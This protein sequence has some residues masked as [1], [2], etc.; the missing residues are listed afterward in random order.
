[1]ASPIAGIRRQVV[2]DETLHNREANK[3]ISTIARMV[4]PGLVKR[5]LTKVFYEH[6]YLLY[7]LRLYDID[8]YKKHY[9]FQ[10]GNVVVDVGAHRGLCTVSLAKLVGNEGR[11]IAIEPDPDNLRFLRRVTAGLSNVVIVEKALWSSRGTMRLYIHENNDGHSLFKDMVTARD[12]VKLVEIQVD[13]LDNI[14]ATLNVK[15]GRAHV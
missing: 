6:I 15:I 1:V 11:V 2:E 8:Y 5:T 3:I 13:T 10:K 4:P 9:K 14:L 7:R 12:K